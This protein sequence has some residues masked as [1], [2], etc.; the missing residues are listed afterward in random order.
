[1]KADCYENL[2]DE[3]ISRGDNAETKLCCDS[4]SSPLSLL[5]PPPPGS[6]GLREKYENTELK[7]M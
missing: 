5:S 7:G 2:C 4:E 1:M 3:A 6:T